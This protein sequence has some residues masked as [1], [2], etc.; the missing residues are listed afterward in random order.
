[1]QEKTLEEE[2]VEKGADLEHERWSRWQK[3]LHSLCIKNDDGTLTIPK[4]RVERWERQI[5][6][7]YAE[8]SEQEK[9]YDRVEVRKYIPLVAELISSREEKAREE[10]RKEGYES[11]PK[12]LYAQEVITQYKEELLEKINKLYQDE[13][14]VDCIDGETLVETY[15]YEETHN[16]ALSEVKK[17]L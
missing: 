4:R 1:M 7:S 3:Y 11:H 16:N 15:G 6:T 8:L 5:A 17:L 9:E 13:R 2:F 10:G 14:P 12:V